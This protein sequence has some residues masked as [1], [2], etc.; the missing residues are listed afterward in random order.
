MGTVLHIVKK[1]KTAALCGRKKFKRAYKWE[2]R[3][4]AVYSEYDVCFKCLKELE[5]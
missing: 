3:K 5:K 4:L 2:D 1:D